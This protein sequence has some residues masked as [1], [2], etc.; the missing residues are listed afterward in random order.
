MTMTMPSRVCNCFDRR[1]EHLRSTMEEEGAGFRCHAL[2]FGHRMSGASCSR[3]S[4]RHRETAGIAHHHRDPI[5][6]DVERAGHELGECGAY[7]SSELDLARIDRDRPLESMV[8]RALL[9]PM[10]ASAF[11]LDKVSTP[12]VC[13]M[14]PAPLWQRT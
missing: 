4:R 1:A 12:G 7:S 6:R 5:E 3:S 13:R 11:E 8:S 2:Q 9:R 10:E 14:A